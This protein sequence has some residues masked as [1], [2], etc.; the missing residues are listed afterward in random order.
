MNSF[1]RH[2]KVFINRNASTILTVVGGIGVV[3]TTVMAV[4]ATPKALALLEQ[5]KEEKG[6]DLSAFETVKV[7]GPA[8]VPAV[9]VG[10][11]TI[12]CIFGANALNKKQQAALMSAYALL[13]S[14]YKDYKKKVEELYGEDAD[15]NV[16]SEL[17][18]DNYDGTVVEDGKRLFY[19]EFSERYF[20]STTE[21][22]LQA[23]YDINRIISVDGGAFL[24]E[25]YEALDIPTIEYG[26]YMGWS[27]C[28]MY[29]YGYGD[30][31]LDFGHRKVVLEDGLECCIISFSHD[32]SYD[33]LDY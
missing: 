31:W 6:E 22:V 11:S 32:P 8:Y 2:S 19:D 5:A 21:K 7:A 3:V 26:D 4:K 14:S 10:S 29:E 25:F 24:N 27:A 12:A 1:L 20:E 17:A 9:V 30:S 18:K 13:D 23:E 33:F 16:R 28:E 15:A